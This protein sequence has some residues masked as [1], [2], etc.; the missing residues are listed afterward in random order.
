MNELDRRAKEYAEI[1]RVHEG[2]IGRG[3][4]QERKMYLQGPVFETTKEILLSFDDTFLK[5]HYYLQ[6]YF[7]WSELVVG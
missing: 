3:E 6:I 4:D 5:R 1:L 2:Y 7:S